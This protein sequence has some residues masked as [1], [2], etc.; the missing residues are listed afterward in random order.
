MPGFNGTGPKG[1]GPR[2]GGGYGF[3]AGTVNS[4][5]EGVEE[6]RG[7]GRGG[8]PQGGGRGKMFR[9]RAPRFPKSRKKAPTL[10]W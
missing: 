1:E 8:F 10:Q 5:V 6:L 9:W 2:T 7:A 4:N 3:C